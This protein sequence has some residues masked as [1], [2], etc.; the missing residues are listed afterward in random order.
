MTRSGGYWLAAFFTLACTT[1]RQAA[2]P[3]VQPSS[4]GL[5][6][7]PEA[8][9]SS[10][11]SRRATAP[12]YLPGSTSHSLVTYQTMDG[13]AVMEG[14]I[15]LGPTQLLFQRYG[16][17][18]I[19][20]NGAKSA[21]AVSDQ[22]FL[23]PKGEIP[24]ELD[25]SVSAQQSDIAWAIAHLATTPIKLRPRTSGDA[26][27]VIFSNR[28][29]G[30][31]SE[32][33]RV[34]GAQTIQ[35]EPDCGR[36]G[37]V[38]EVLHAAGFM[39]EQSRA[40]RDQFVTIV[41]D[42]IA[43]GNESNFEQRPKLS[44]D[45]GVYDYDSIMHYGAK[46]FS[47]RGNPTIVPKD[48]KARIGNREGLS[49]L[50]RAAIAQMYGTAAAPTPI[51]PAL[52]SP[53]PTAAP[54]PQPLPAPVTMGSFAGQYSSNLGAVTCTQNANTVQCAFSEGS[55]LCAANG[56]QLDCGWSGKGIGRAVL[57]RQANGNLVG[58]W[59][60]AFSANSRGSLTLQ[61]TTSGGQAPTPTAPAP[62][63]VTSPTPAPTP[64]ANS[65]TPLTGNFTSTRGAM[66]C[67][68]I[69]ARVT[70]SF[71]E[72]SG[73]DGRLDCT[74]DAT[75]LTLACTWATFLPQPA[76]GR[77]SFSRPGTS[78]RTLTGTWGLFLAD[79]GGGTW[80]AQGQ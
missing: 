22:A 44:Q 45:V 39:H 69:D 7:S 27:Y 43:Q 13:L 24:F 49:A 41:W 74:K 12:L 21:V 19:Q 59:G 71:R 34:R 53:L 15:V 33:G 5:P 23:W 29:S 63:P 75:G 70:C 40:D 46:Y 48:P 2:G 26:D 35:I 42:E 14:D 57:V 9:Q 68:E 30:C 20:Q 55:L 25:A 28:D 3:G 52:P 50:D 79:T 60:D 56:S 1:Q 65:A 62:V 80:N 51:E 31:W 38:H 73:A 47:R 32:L 67:S 36:G 18:R 11:I 16:S 78:S 77:A 54:S 8:Y 64:A 37:I 58:S 76:A 4:F 66:T 10:S 17:P 72:A 61:P 6:P